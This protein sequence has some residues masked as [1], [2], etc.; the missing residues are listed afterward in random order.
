MKIVLGCGVA[1][2]LVAAMLGAG[3]WFIFFRD[4]PALDATLAAPTT[5]I[6]GETLALTVTA[7]NP[8]PQTVILDSVDIDD[9]LLEGFQVVGVTPRARDTSHIFHMRTWS[10]GKAVPPGMVQTIRFDLRAIEAG[11]FSGDID[12]CNPNQDF[13]TLLGDIVVEAAGPEAD[14]P[15]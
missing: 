1:A 13:V 11:H 14:P 2:A 8:H 6:A 12:V 4:L 10:F 15:D 9:S 3:I 5:V 7:S